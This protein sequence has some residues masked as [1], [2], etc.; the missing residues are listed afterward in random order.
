LPGD[1]DHR[2]RYRQRP[3]SFFDS[4][5]T[6]Q[7]SNKDKPNVKGITAKQIFKLYPEVNE[8]RWEGEFWTKVFYV[9]KVARHIDEDLIQ[10][11]LYI[12]GRERNIKNS[13]STD[14]FALTPHLPCCEVALFCILYLSDKI[15]IV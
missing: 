13:Y 10:K 9:N 14:K 1:F 7:K 3:C 15:S 5:C 6:V 2:D 8:K 12:E 4:A 11:D